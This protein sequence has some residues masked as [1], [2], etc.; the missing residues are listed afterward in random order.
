[1]TRYPGFPAGD[2]AAARTLSGIDWTTTALGPMDQWPAGLK[3]HL[4]LIFN[5]PE[6]MYVLWGPD[7][8]F[9]HN[10]AY[11]PVL[12]PRLKNAMGARMKELWSDVWDQVESNIEDALRGIPYQCE[13]LPLVMARYG[14]IERTWWSFSFSPVI[15]EHNRIAGLLCV[16]KETTK[17][18]L[19]QRAL[20]AS[21]QRRL[22]LIADL[23]RQVIERSHE[24]GLTWQVSPDLLSVMTAELQFETTNP[25]WRSTLGWSDDELSSKTLGNLIHPHDTVHTQ[26]AF[27]AL[28]GNHPVLNLENRCLHKDGTYRWLSWVAVPE[29][30]K[31][32]CSARDITHE[33]RQADALRLAED[34]LRQSQKME[35]V[36]QLTGGLAHDFNNLLLG[37]SGNLEL[38][39]NRVAR[40]RTE[41]LDRYIDSALEGSRRAAALTHRLL[42]YSRRQTLDP[43]VT[44]VDHLV[45][46]M[47]ELIRRTVGPAIAMDVLATRGLWTTRVD[48]HQLENA[49][50]N[51]CLNARDA[52]PDGGQLLIE[53]CN[54]TLDAAD[55][56]ELEL[57]EG[58]Y[59]ALSV[60]DN[61]TGM[62]QEV[63]KRAFEP[64]FT[65]KPMGMGTGLGLSMIYGFARQS[66]GGVRIE[67]TLGR[68]SRVCIYLP[69]YIGTEKPAAKTPALSRSAAAP[70]SGKTV[71]VV[72]DE[73]SVRALMSEVL[74]DQG[75]RVLEADTGASA[76]EIL[77]SGQTV[78]LLVSDV[79][80]PGGMNGRQLA[81]A[82]RVWRPTLDVLFVTG[83]A[84]NAALDKDGLETGMHVLI[85]PF[86]LRAFN[87]R[88]IE[89]L[90]AQRVPPAKEAP[91]SDPA[92]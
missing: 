72:D 30:G 61:G 87:D 67:S 24:R 68:G 82:A 51:L 21:E 31:M 1:M 75:Y 70:A 85:K 36:G 44:D 15:D 8:L 52:M 34:A 10:D 17:R 35:A 86:S 91:F 9:F 92:P 84:E 2:S 28:K 12:G 16:T 57:P 66:G 59:V 79:G 18:V 3:I 6:S 22:D 54:E 32:Y 4:N 73:P 88:V 55:A 37:V 29:G 81:D 58:R 69:A 64:F 63:A 14:E 11:A 89:L 41:Q 90:R 19:D 13:D 74:I 7:L 78:D 23:E 50:L 45:E 47:A 60:S 33:K 20:R 5:S 49:L 65:T 42:A 80:L 83:Y 43:E 53:T 46:G 71:L 48:A 77:Q 40:G 25:A 56:Q 62:S 27:E 26:N 38:L 76:L 39:K